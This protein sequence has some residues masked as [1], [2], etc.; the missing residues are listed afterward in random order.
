MLNTLLEEEAKQLIGAEKYERS[1]GR[2][3]TRA[4]YYERGFDMKAGRMMLKVPKLRRLTFKT[5]IIERNIHRESSVEEAL[6]KMYPAG[7]SV[8]RVEDIILASPIA[9]R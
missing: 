5:A 7:V 6:I 9:P 4:G 3:D 1:E 2:R 8:R